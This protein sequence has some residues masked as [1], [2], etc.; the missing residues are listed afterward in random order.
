MTDEQILAMIQKG[1]KVGFEKYVENTQE[2]DEQFQKKL[3]YW[4]CMACQEGSLMIVKYLYESG[5]VPDVNQIESFGRTPLACAIIKNQQEVIDYLREKN[6]DLTARVNINGYPYTYLTLALMSGNDNLAQYLMDETGVIPEEMDLLSACENDHPDILEK[7]LSKGV[8]ANTIN[9]NPSRGGAFS[10]LFVACSKNQINNAQLLIHYGADVNCHN[11]PPDNVTALFIAVQNGNYRLAQYLINHGA[12]VNDGWAKCSPLYI[13][14]STNNLDVVSL[15]LENGADPDLGMGETPPIVE[16]IKQ[17]NLSIVKLLVQYGANENNRFT[18]QEEVMNNQKFIFAENQTVSPIEFAKASKRTEIYEFLVSGDDKEPKVQQME[19]K[20]DKNE[21]LMQ[22]VLD[23]KLEVVEK[24]LEEGASANFEEKNETPLFAAVR[25]GNLQMVECLLKHG[26]NP[27]SLCHGESKLSPIYDACV[28]GNLQIMEALLKYHANPD[29]RTI[30][31]VSVLEMAV[32]KGNEQMVK[33]L[34]EGG[35]NP[36][37]GVGEEP[38]IISAIRNNKK[39]LV[40]MLLAYKADVN[41]PVEIYREEFSG[42]NSTRITY[43]YFSP[44]QY[45]KQMG[46]EDFCRMMEAYMKK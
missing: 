15:L 10:A 5:L 37:L 28:R 45:A 8:D 13:A 36:N 9:L 18:Y 23:G 6:V 43:G 21:K 33:A 7:I 42:S 39:E 40:Q 24:K 19:S 38:P 34:L 12:K 4:F 16:A 14:C 22:D 1:D 17:D 46:K 11:N 27:D 25:M 44:Y 26:A 2:K 29:Y 3:S 32:H 20:E 30:F 35:A 31:K 41:K